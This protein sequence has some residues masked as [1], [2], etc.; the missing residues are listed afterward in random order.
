[1]TLSPKLKEKLKKA[2]ID[3]KKMKPVTL[4]LFG[5][6]KKTLGSRG[7]SAMCTSLSMLMESV[8]LSIVCNTNVCSV[9]KSQDLI[10]PS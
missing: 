2:V 1:M 7:V 8:L 3:V 9:E 4:I 6:P 10:V 5:K